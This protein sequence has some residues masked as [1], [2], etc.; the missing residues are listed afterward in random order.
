LV[1]SATIRQNSGAYSLIALFLNLGNKGKKL[2]PKMK[3][4][5]AQLINARKN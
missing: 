5:K 3:Q 1:N 4:Q 2:S